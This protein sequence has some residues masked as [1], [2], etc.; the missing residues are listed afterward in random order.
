LQGIE[1][2][3]KEKMTG[4]FGHH[5]DCRANNCDYIASSFRDLKKHMK[6]HYI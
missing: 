1:G 3:E 5:L 4:V 6:K 2:I